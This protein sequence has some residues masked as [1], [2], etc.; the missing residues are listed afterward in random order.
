M[1]TDSI[2]VIVF[3][4]GDQ[5]QPLYNIISYNVYERMLGLS[6]TP[7]KE[8]ILKDVIAGKKL[9]REG[10]QKATMGMVAGTKPSHS[11]DSYVGQY[12]NP[13]Y[14]IVNISMKDQHLQFK[15][16]KIE[17][18]LSH[19]HYD[20][21]DTP[22]D[23]ELGL[24]AL[25]FNTNPQGDIDRFVVS[26]DEKEAIFVR[27]PDA[28]LTDPK[29]LMD[30]TG[31]YEFA[32]FVLEIVLKNENQLFLTIPGQPNTELIA[33]K[34]RTFKV[35]DFEDYTIEFIMEN[36]KVTTMKQKDPSGEYESK[37]K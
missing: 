4:I 3:V 2:G 36:G 32:G 30:Y 27:R 34:A 26:L 16:H 22:N 24:Y 17:L 10:R 20:R 19:F 31:K 25:N 8:R 5:S 12:E 21:F 14:G 35:K 6:Q 18:P 7:W 13:G 9:G 15:L 37:R 1:P 33:Y 23:E 11:L 29:V 28:D